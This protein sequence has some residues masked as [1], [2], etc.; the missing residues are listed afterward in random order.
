MR[1]RTWLIVCGC[2]AGAA[3]TALAQPAEPVAPD[4]AAK[5][6]EPATPAEPAAPPEAAEPAPVTPSAAFRLPPVQF[7]GFVSQGAF[8]STSNDYIGKSSQGSVEMF[9]AGLN[10][11]TEVA[12]RLR[13]GI[14]FFARDVG[15]FRDL[16]PRL[17]WA[18]LD[19]RWRSWLGLRAGVIKLPY[20]LYNE[21]A[22]I[23]AARLPILLPQSVYQLRNRSALLAQTGFALY[24]DKELGAAGSIE[25]QAFLGTLNIPENALVIGGA[26]L[27]EIDTKYVTG[28]QVFWH[29]PLEGLRVGASYVRASID[30]NLTLDEANTEALIMAGLVPPEFDGKVTVAQRPSQ[31]IIGSA[32]YVHNDWLFAAEYARSLKRQR[33]TLPMNLLALDEDQERA[34]VMVNRRFCRCF[35]AGLYYSVFN[36]DVDDRRG[37]DKTKFPERWYAWQRDAAVTLRYDVNDHW[38]W[39]LE[40]HFIDG[41]ADLLGSTANPDRYWGLFLLKTTVTF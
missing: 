29:P 9:E 7:H 17:D 22:D 26:T 10:M 38:F 21:Y 32:E 36:S 16:P 33:S 8:Y 30:F 1:D 41:V 2:L 4:E 35:E 3:S 20:G 12:D 25:Y 15:T 40:G 39:K 18:F 13:A 31:F 24:G 5:P 34:Y 28:G 19:Y 23:D 6:A 27:D 37:H 14:Q 11:S